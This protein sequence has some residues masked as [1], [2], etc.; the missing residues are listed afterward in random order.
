MTSSS[1]II[2]KWG[3]ILAGSAA[4][5]SVSA[6]I[7]T[8]YLLKMAVDREEPKLMK[9]AGKRV[10]GFAE[11]DSFF[12]ARLDAGDRLSKKESETVDITSHDGILLVG[13]WIPAV[14]AKRILI[15]VHGWRASWYE[16]FGIVSDSW[17]ENDCSVL[18]I[19]QRA[20][21]NSGGEY[22]GFGLTERFDCLDW[23]S[24]VNRNIGT[25]LPIY[26]V[27]VSMGAATVLM[28]A[29]LC[30][31]E[32]VHGI[33]A[34]C[35]YTSPH[36]IWKHVA[37]NNLHITYGVRGMI[38][39]E[40]LRQKIQIGSN[41]FSTTEALKQTQIPVL[42]IHGTD[43]HFVPVQMTYENYLACSGPR[44]LLIVPGA[45]HGMSYFTDPERYTAAVLDFW[46]TFDDW[47]GRSPK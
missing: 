43:D 1:K 12:K 19:E 29:D 47:K 41:D 21:D 8:R 45:D 20:H 4:I 42:L 37:N 46:K 31:P 35:G 28:A 38:A 18:Y 22:M 39:S 32:N 7:T 14:N 15:A 10:A 33:I 40:I 24:W 6:F 44:R 27:G 5:A 23:V 36:A 11:D 2:I 16:T 25:D 9:L 3:G 30:L 34:D 13:H 17:M 26:L